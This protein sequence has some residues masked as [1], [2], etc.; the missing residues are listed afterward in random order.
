MQVLVLLL[1]SRISHQILLLVA[2]VPPFCGPLLRRQ[3]KAEEE[4]RASHRYETG[5]QYFAKE[6]KETKDRLHT[7]WPPFIFTLQNVIPKESQ[8]ASGVPRKSKAFSPER[9]ICMEKKRLFGKEKTT[10]LSQLA[11]ERQ[12]PFSQL[13][14]SKEAEKKGLVS[15][16][17]GRAWLAGFGSIPK[18]VSSTSKAEPPARPSLKTRL[19]G[20]EEAVAQ[21]RGKE[22]AAEGDS[23][24]MHKNQWGCL[25]LEL[26]LG[27]ALWVGK[28][29]V[30]RLRRWQMWDLGPHF[31]ETLGR[32]ELSSKVVSALFH[33]SV[34]SHH[35]STT[36]HFS[37][38]SLTKSLVFSSVTII[39]DFLN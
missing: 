16:T 4:V 39:G 18:T 5:K 37:H 14:K 36:D 29:W 11:F 1:G 35:F 12:F 33:E 25:D 28:P 19:L 3:Q 31:Q 22:E 6:L 26:L 8:K 32:K 30:M 9:P 38:P 20:A 17:W 34:S 7:K 13:R 24:S 10:D 23:D 2:P 21:E 27:G 15:E